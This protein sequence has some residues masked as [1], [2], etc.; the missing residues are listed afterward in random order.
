MKIDAV[1]EESTLSKL[2]F[3][4]RYLTEERMLLSLSLMLDVT[5]PEE[6]DEI[7]AGML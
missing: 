6:N 1:V 3:Y 5:T 7:A 2:K 4:L